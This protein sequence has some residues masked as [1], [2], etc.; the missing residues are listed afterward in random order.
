MKYEKEEEK[1]ERLVATI[2]LSV[3]KGMIRSLSR[4]TRW[5]NRTNWLRFDRGWLRMLPL[6]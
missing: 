6:A 1:E 3:L 2:T 5:S 4:Q